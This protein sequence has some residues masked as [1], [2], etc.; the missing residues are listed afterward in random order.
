MTHLHGSQ[1]GG[2]AFGSDACTA[3][4]IHADL[5]MGEVCLEKQSVGDD[6][7]ICAKS[8]ERDLLKFPF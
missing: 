5:R 7:N 4:G 2:V 1:S 6:T 3:L 8:K